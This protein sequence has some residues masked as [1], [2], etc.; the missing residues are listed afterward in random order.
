MK[1]K[2][3]LPSEPKWLP[4]SSAPW[5]RWVSHLCAWSWLVPCMLLMHL[6][7]ALSKCLGAHLMRFWQHRPLIIYFEKWLLCPRYVIWEHIL[8][9]TRHVNWKITL[10]L[11]N[12]I[13][14]ETWALYKITSKRIYI[15]M[16]CTI[17]IC[18]LCKTWVFFLFP[19]TSLRNY[20]CPLIITMNRACD[21]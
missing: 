4:A 14:P 10:F 7:L 3:S 6:V 16:F 9:F 19:Y 13:K 11:A 1:G 5:L 12:T 17:V 2:E 8:R 21:L 15:P 20:L 18:I